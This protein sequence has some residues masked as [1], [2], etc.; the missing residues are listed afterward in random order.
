MVPLSQGIWVAVTR[1]LPPMSKMGYAVGVADSRSLKHPYTQA[2]VGLFLVTNTLFLLPSVP[3]ESQTFWREQGLRSQTS[4]VSD[5][6]PT[7]S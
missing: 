3:P 2:P 5:L 7:I 4:W 6:A 1:P